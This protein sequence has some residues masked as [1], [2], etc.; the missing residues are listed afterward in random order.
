MVRGELLLGADTTS[1]NSGDILRVQASVCN[2]SS[3]GQ[4]SETRSIRAQGG[5][6]AGCWL[7]STTW[8]WGG[9]AF[10]GFDAS[11]PA[12]L[13]NTHPK[14]V[15]LYLFSWLALSYRSFVVSITTASQKLV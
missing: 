15:F 3:C 4:Q 9:G 11:S 1:N 13:E 7:Q 8:F 14:R 10:F 6:R 12:R 2:Q 5:S